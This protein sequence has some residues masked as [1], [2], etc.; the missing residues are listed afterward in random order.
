M[1]IN[2]IS[3]TAAKQVNRTRTATFNHTVATNTTDYY[4]QLNA[5]VTHGGIIETYQV[6][7][8]D[9]FT[10]VDIKEVAVY[11]G[12]SSHSPSNK[13]VEMA[14]GGFQAVFLSNA[15]LE[16]SDNKYFRVA[17]ED[18][19]PVEI[20]GEVYV[21]GSMQVR[22]RDVKHYCEIT[23][24]LR[25]NSGSLAAPALQFGHADDGFFHAPSAV[26][27]TSVAGVN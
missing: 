22:A 11:F 4:Y 6:G 25:P 26:S 5:T 19:K 21:T 14:P 10:D 17:P 2:T 24:H 18:D 3:T 27:N 8:K 16:D 15:T 23:H 1:N 13:K 20:L 9:F 7:P 12:Q